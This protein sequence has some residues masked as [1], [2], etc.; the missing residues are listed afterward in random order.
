MDLHFITGRIEPW[1]LAIAVAFTFVAT[2]VF[3]PWAIVRLPADY[4]HYHAR[5]RA[6]A[7]TA[8]PVLRL[9]LLLAKNIG[10][11]ILVVMGL[12]MLVLPGQGL[13]TILMGVLLLDFPGKF[14]F[15][16]WLV[17]RKLIL[18]SCNWLRAKA[19]KA[20]LWLG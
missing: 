13:L 17:S 6:L 10:G 3:V 2:L 1:M 20:P 4:F 11:C 18:R 8:H 14:R 16:R 9:L 19:H 15:E 12:A 7:N 5:H